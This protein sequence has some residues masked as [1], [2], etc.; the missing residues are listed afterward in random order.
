MVPPSEN[1]HFPIGSVAQN[2]T[3]PNIEKLRSLSCP[4]GHEY[5][6]AGGI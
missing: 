2:K 3:N 6:I 1:E 5:R 4:T